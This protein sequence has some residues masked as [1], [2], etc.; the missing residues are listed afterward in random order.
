MKTIQKENEKNV[1]TI[2]NILKNSDIFFIEYNCEF[3]FEYKQSNVEFIRKITNFACN[4][5]VYKEKYNIRNK[6]YVEL[7]LSVKRFP[8]D[9][10]HLKDTFNLIVNIQ[11]TSNKVE[12]LFFKFIILSEILK[13][14]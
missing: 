8:Q 9:N 13:N 4:I 7:N 2:K 10:I 12:I 1:Q 5:F 6:K 3:Y 14:L 11:N